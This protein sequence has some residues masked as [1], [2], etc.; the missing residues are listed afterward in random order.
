MRLPIKG[1]TLVMIG[2]IVLLLALFTYVALCS[3]S[4]APVLVTV[5]MPSMANA[6]RVA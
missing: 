2:V 3:G 5:T 6:T 1:R 4:L